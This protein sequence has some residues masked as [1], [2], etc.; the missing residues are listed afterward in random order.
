MYMYESSTVA[1]H[2]QVAW[3]LCDTTL[4]T[5]FQ[6]ISICF[7]SLQV[8][9]CLSSRILE[10]T[11]TANPPITLVFRKVIQKDCLKLAS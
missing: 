10:W 5:H 3:A 9:L 7:L 8:S 6:M 4:A 11:G 2:V 1:N